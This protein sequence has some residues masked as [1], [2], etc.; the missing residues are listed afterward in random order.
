M[1]SGFILKKREKNTRGHFHQEISKQNI[2]LIISTLLLRVW[3]QYGYQKKRNSS[4]KSI[5]L[6]WCA[7]F[8][9]KFSK[10][11]KTLKIGQKCR[12]TAS[13]QP[14]FE[15]CSILA[16][17]QCTKLKKLTSLKNF[18]SFGTHLAPKLVIIVEKL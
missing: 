8:Q 4:G 5:L 13:F 15:V 12:N 14:F 16:K 6:V 17:K 11:Q 1:K 3:G 18:A 7:V 10:L 2:K 9:S